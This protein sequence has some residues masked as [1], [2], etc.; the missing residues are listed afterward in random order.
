MDTVMQELLSRSSWGARSPGMSTRVRSWQAHELAL[1]GSGTWDWQHAYHVERGQQGHSV[2]RFD[3]MLQG[4]V[5][6]LMDGVL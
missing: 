3:S 1:I 2:G 4:F 6:K 5:A